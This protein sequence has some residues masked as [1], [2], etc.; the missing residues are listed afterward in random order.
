MYP[1]DEKPTELPEEVLRTDPVALLAGACATMLLAGL[2]LILSVLSK[3][4]GNRASWNDGKPLEYIEARLLTL[5]EIKD[6]DSM[7][8]RI[9]P[10]LPTVPEEVLP[11]DM[12]EKKEEPPEKPPQ[13]PPQREAVTDEKL[14][15]VLDKARAFAEIQDDY[16]PE[17]HP[18]GVEDGDVA[19][20]RLASLGDTYGRK[21]SRLIAERWIVPTLLSESDLRRLSATV[22]LRVDIDMTIVSVE[23]TKESGNAMFDDTITN[24]IELVQTEVRQLPPPPEAIA[25]MI[26]GGG[27]LLRMNGSDAQRE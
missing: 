24:A 6:P 17:G 11:L 7:P 2:F 8:D 16:V 21:I 3:T 4:A 12:D 15:T 13:E 27:I 23:F 5:G 25:P 20:P 18:E 1:Q 26:F 14:R 22:L 19:D 9:V 10:A